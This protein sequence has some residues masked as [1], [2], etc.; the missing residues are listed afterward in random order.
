[1]RLY[2]PLPMRFI[3]Q[4]HGCETSNDEGGGLQRH[5]YGPRSAGGSIT[6]CR[7]CSKQIRKK[8]DGGMRNGVLAH[9]RCHRP[10]GTHR[11]YTPPPPPLVPVSLPSLPVP[12]LLPQWPQ[13]HEQLDALVSRPPPPLPPTTRSARARLATLAEVPAHPWATHDWELQDP[14]VLHARLAAEWLAFYQQIKER[15]GTWTELRGGGQQYDTTK[16][17]NRRA[18]DAK[19]ITLRSVTEAAMRATLQA[20]GVDTAS[21]HLAAMKMLRS[22]PGGKD[23]HVH[24]DISNIEEASTRWSMLLYCN[25]TMST[26]MPLK[27]AQAM[28]PAFI[29]SHTATADQQLV[30]EE[31]CNKKNFISMPVKPGNVLAFKTT[32]AHYGV[33][34]QGSEDRVVI[35]ALFSPDDKAYQ[36]EEQRFP[37]GAPDSP[38]ASPEPIQPPLKKIR[39]DTLAAVGLAQR[40]KSRPPS[41]MAL[42]LLHIASKVKQGLSFDA[43]VKETAAT[44]KTSPRTL[45][46]AFQLYQEMGE[47]REPSTSQRGRGN[48]THSLNSNNTDEFGP[49]L[50]AELLMHELVHKQKEE[51][52][53]ITSTI[54]SAELRSRL[55]VAVSRRTVRRWLHALGYRWRHKRYVGG[56][57]PQA[58]NVRIRQFILEY[59]A[60]LSEEEAG[61]AI[62]VYMDESY[63]HSHHATKKGWFHSSNSDVIGDGDGKR[64]I[65]LHAMTDSGLLAVPDEIASN[66]LNEPSLTAEL[67]FEE[68]LEDGEDNSDYHNTMTGAKFVAWLRNRLLPTFAELYPGKKMFLVLD[69]ASYH[70]PRDESWVS[71]SK[72][73]NKHEL[74]HTLLDLGV[75]ELTTAGDKPRT[76]PAH[77]F[78]AAVSAGGP[79]KDDLLAA[80]QKWL[81]EH[82]D[83]NRTVVEQLMSDAGHSLVYTPPFCPEVQPIELLWA[84][85][86][87]YVADRST[88]NRSMTET[89]EQTEGAFEQITKM[90]CNSI[91]RH[92]HD[93]ID[94]FIASEAAEELQQ[95]GTLAGVIKHLSLLNATSEQIPPDKSTVLHSTIPPLHPS[96]PASAATPARNLRRRH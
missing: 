72:A 35:Y 33:A 37:L 27:S 89:R 45:R 6:L 5:A 94:Q 52:T 1:M 43:A 71:G 84:Q 80:V 83:H 49:S 4:S 70:K 9:H 75:T 36:D 76:V 2:A 18:E 62:V 69:N 82:P 67:V 63:I 39:L 38:V 61:R 91:V 34:A 16:E 65:I 28:A 14:T 96:T 23:Q 7:L 55:N 12:P 90:L 85:I 66:W 56:M 77:R 30:C 29:A 64:L 59:A 41:A 88:H 44:E 78:E 50:D 24:F 46:A 74:A 11:V 17:I 26:A 48:P 40:G 21:L 68:V 20:L 51:G 60:A 79:S 15:P 8:S 47:I 86:K 58:R 42:S 73:K 32:V 19:R 87:R 25:E 93:W 92:C 54:I 31:L 95:C 3:E 57:K 13:L 81:D 10:S 53:S 22:Q